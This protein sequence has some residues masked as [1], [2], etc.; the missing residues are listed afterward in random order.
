LLNTHDISYDA[1]GV[2]Q[3]FTRVHQIENQS[4]KKSI[5]GLLHV[6]LSYEID[7]GN[8][9]IRHYVATPLGHIEEHADR[10]SSASHS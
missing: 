9:D 2:Q 5:Y 1:K 3:G 8:T 6:D 7:D 10:G 4:L